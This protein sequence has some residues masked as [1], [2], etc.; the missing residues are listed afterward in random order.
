VAAF[1]LLRAALLGCAVFLT[2]APAHFPAEARF[3]SPEGHGDRASDRRH[4]DY[5]LL[6]TSTTVNFRTNWIGDLLCCGAQYQIEHHLFPTISHAYYPQMSPIVRRFCDAH[7][8]PYQSI[9]WGE[10]IVKS[11]GVFWRPKR[12]EPQ[13]AAGCR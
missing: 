8:Y 12:V 2:A 7:G 3:L 4:A 6:Q 1:Y 11:L 13:L 10:G 5:I 9:G